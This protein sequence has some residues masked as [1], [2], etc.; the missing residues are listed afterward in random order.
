MDLL[1][2][3]TDERLEWAEALEQ[4]RDPGSTGAA[5]SR[6]LGTR[7][8]C[9]PPG[10]PT[11]ASVARLHPVARQDGGEVLRGAPRRLPGQRPLRGGH[12]PQ[13]VHGCAF[14]EPV[15]RHGRAGL[16]H[17]R[18]GSPIRLH[19]LPEPLASTAPAACE[20]SR[21]RHKEDL[22]QARRWSDWGPSD[23]ARL[24]SPRAGCEQNSDQRPGG[25]GRGG[26]GQGNARAEKVQILGLLKPPLSQLP[27]E[28][29]P[30]VGSGRPLEA[31]GGARHNEMSGPCLVPN[32]QPELP[33]RK[34]R[35]LLAQDR[36][37]RE[38]S[39]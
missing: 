25:A 17:H 11:P 24:N 27:D 31:G 39:P 21:I 1:L 28:P 18:M 38:S 3:S 33:T 34:S 8:R 30:P 14:Q 35:N 23:L 32:D 37:C 29:L 6:A 16:R 10:L 19:R 4:R 26:G 5:S 22:S 2:R 9:R 20:A 36:R 13:A 12:L 15:A 7:P